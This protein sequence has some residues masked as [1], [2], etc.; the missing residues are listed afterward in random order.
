MQRAETPQKR[1]HSDWI[2]T[3]SVINLSNIYI[4]FTVVCTGFL[5]N[6]YR[7]DS[8]M[9]W[10]CTD[11]CQ[12]RVNTANVYLFDSSVNWICAA[13]FDTI[14][15]QTCDGLCYYGVNHACTEHFDSS[16]ASNL[17][18]WSYVADKLNISQ[19]FGQRAWN[20]YDSLNLARLCKTL[21]LEFL[22]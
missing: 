20:P 4:F 13:V 8:D 12:S 11:L 9:N 6:V 2:L 3:N 18:K 10:I 14:V 1:K 7:F 22:G 15:N 16:L 5:A 21:W 17:R 19:L